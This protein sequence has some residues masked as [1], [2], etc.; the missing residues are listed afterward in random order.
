MH[1]LR[2]VLALEDLVWAAWLAVLLP[3]TG[4]LFLEGGLVTAFLVAAALGFWTAALLGERGRDLPR[5][6]HALGA[7]MFVCVLMIDVGL[8][9]T[10]APVVLRQVNTFGAIAL[11]IFATWQHRKTGGRTFL[12]APRILRRGLAWPFLMVMAS[13]FEAIL[14]ALFAPNSGTLLTDVSPGEAVFLLAFVLGLVMPLLFTCFVVALRVTTCPEGQVDAGVWALR[15]IWA[16]A[17]ALV[18]A[19][20]VCPWFAGS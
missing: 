6:G 14:D 18:G 17:A 5:S 11:G 15:Y 12:A 10:D 1:R 20:V 13:L 8:K 19:Q 9:Q 4:E 2:H 3:A 7:A 16:L